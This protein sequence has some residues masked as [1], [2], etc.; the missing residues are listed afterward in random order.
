ME[1][2]EIPAQ[3]TTA[4]E[5]FNAAVT[6]TATAIEKAAEEASKTAQAAPDQIAHETMSNVNQALNLLN[7]ELKRLND[8]NEYL[9]NQETVASGAAAEVAAP[10]TPIADVVEGKAARKV[11]R[12]A[13][14]V[15]R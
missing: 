8:H 10:V 13:R 15:N 2:L 4:P 5:E 7:S 9:K 14:K 3:V 1:D 12:G 6:T 11:R